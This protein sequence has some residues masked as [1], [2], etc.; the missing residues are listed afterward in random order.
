MPVLNNKR[1]L[2]VFIMLILLMIVPLGVLTNIGFDTYQ[3]LI[4]LTVIMQIFLVWKFRETQILIIITLYLFMYFLYFI[5]Y[6]YCDIQ[7]SQY[8]QFQNKKYFSNV[9]FLF[10]L[11]YAGMTCATKKEINPYHVKLVNIIRIDVAPLISIVYTLFTVVIF[12]KVMNQGQNVLLEGRNYSAYIDNLNTVGALP[13]FFILVILFTFF[14]IRNKIKRNLVFGLLCLGILYFSITRGFRMVL[15]PVGMM[16]FVTFFDSRVKTRTVL[17]LFILGFLGL[18]FVNSLKMNTQFDL[19]HAFAEGNHDFI[20]SHHA[21]NL[22]IG[23]AGFGLIERNYIGFEERVLLNLGFFSEIIIPPK[24]LPNTMKYPHIITKSV[25]TGG[26]G[27][28]VMASYMMWGY[29]GV[30]LFGYLFVRFIRYAY[31]K[32]TPLLA[33]ICMVLVIFSPRWISYDFH[34]ILRFTFATFIIYAFLCWK[35]KF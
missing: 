6:F 10:F 9:L 28:F 20:L 7:L 8:S 21:D 2:Q 3:F 13:L 16:I 26:G 12:I 33:L 22:Y 30:F 18:T 27:L 11:F 15:A 35:L 4:P 29:V 23:A 17:L 24:M 19:K 5:P 34:I 32:R 14:I 25:D 31:I 1:S